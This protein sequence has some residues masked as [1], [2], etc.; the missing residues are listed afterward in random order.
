MSVK[1]KTILQK[2]SASEYRINKFFSETSA[3]AIEHG[4]SASEIRGATMRWLIIEAPV[5]RNA[6]NIGSVRLLIDHEEN[7]KFQVLDA[8]LDSGKLS[9][10]ILDKYLNQMTKG[11]KL[12]PG[13]EQEI[14]LKR[15]SN[16]LVSLLTN[17]DEKFQF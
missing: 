7:F 9:N 11:C 3:H 5:T 6:P 8:T 17:S 4:F 1:H 12:C 15:K 16:F 14:K 13:V 2:V 10:V